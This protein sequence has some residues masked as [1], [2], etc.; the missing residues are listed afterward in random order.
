MAALF[1]ENIIVTILKTQRNG[2]E[3]NFNIWENG[4]EDN[5]VGYNREGK[6]NII[7][8]RR[9]AQTDQTSLKIH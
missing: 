3:S 9:F 1:T 8:E 4:R 7:L 6:R 2:K 5:T